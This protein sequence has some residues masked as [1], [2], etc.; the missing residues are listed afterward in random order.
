MNKKPIM[1]LVLTLAITSLMGTG[2]KSYNQKAKIMVDHWNVGDFQGASATA[3]KYASKQKSETDRDAV[4]W[5]LEQGATLRAAGQ[6]K[7]SIA[8]FDTAEEGSDVFDGKSK[9]KT[10]VNESLSLLTNPTMLPYDGYAYDKIMLNTYKAAD[11]LQLGDFE[12]ARVEFNRALEKQTDALAVNAARIEKTQKAA[13]D[14]NQ[15]IDPEKIKNDPK[16]SEQWKTYYLDLDEMKFYADYQNPFTEYLSGLF[17]MCQPTGGSDL[18]RARKSFELVLGMIGENKFI[19]QDMKMIEQATAGQAISPT[20]YVIF[21][22]GR[23]PSRDEIRIDVPTFLATS[24]VPYVG[25]AFPKLTFHNGNV[26]CLTVKVGDT[27]EAT[28]TLASMDSVIA[29]EF[30]NDLTRVIIRT[31]ASAAIKAGVSYGISE[32]TR[33]HEGNQG[34]QAQ[35]AEIAAQAAWVIYQLVFNHAD[36]RTWNTLPKEIQFCH[37]PTPADRKIEITAEGTAASSTVTIGDG[38]INLVWVKSVNQTTPL[39]VSQCKLK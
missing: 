25:M 29:Q 21:E 7:E 16:F 17:F 4:I 6:Y 35:V 36:M 19:D 12:N 18:Q 31:V 32:A 9:G 39:Q 34:N 23:A 1:R 28:I 8:A 2:C 33:K 3:T 11:Y 5:R 37:F 27:N 14:K 30:K 20:T 13:A 38:I 24:K 15:N 10:A 26:R 22:T